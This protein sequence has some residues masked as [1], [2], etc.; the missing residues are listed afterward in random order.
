MD[1]NDP[2]KRRIYNKEW[3]HKNKDKR[4]QH[5]T[6]Y[7]ENNKETIK[8]YQKEWYQNNKEKVGQQKKEYTQTEVGKKT[9]R[10]S[11]WKYIGIITDDY[12]ALYEKFINTKNCELCNCELTVD[13]RNTKTTRCLDHD[14]S[15]TDRD[16]VRNILCLSC[17]ASLPT[18]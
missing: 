2:E 12:D 16:N 14:H 15:I 4:K 11:S 7:R 9:N 17:N 8:Q 13:K 10:I 5:Q 6:K 1:W 3:Y 18:Q